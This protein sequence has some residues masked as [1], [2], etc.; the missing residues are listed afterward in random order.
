MRDKRAEAIE[1]VRR[2]REAGFQAY[3]AGGCVR[4][5]LLGRTPKDYDIATDA[6]ASQ[7]QRIFPRTVPVG[8][9]FGVV[10]VLSGGHSF[11]VTTFRSDGAYLDARH[12]SEVRF[13]TAEEDAARRDFTINGMFY[14]PLSAQVLD[15][16][17]GREDLERGI[18]R[19]VGEAPKRIAED[20]LR[21]LRAVRLAARL[22]FRIE[23]K[24]RAAIVAA[25]TS[26]TEMAWERIGE[27]VVL[28][29]REGAARRGIELMA[30]CGLLEPVLPEVSGLRGIPQPPAHHPEGDVFEHTLRALGHLEEGVSETLGLG[31]LLHDI[32]KPS[33]LRS[34]ARNGEVTITF[35]GHAE[36][37]AKMAEEVCQR[38]KRSREVRSRVAYLVGQHSRILHAERMRPAKLKRM[39]REEGFAELLELARVDALAA[40]GDLTHYEFCRAR[41]AEL[42]PEQ[43]HPPRLLTGHDLIE[44]GYRPGPLFGSILEKLE[45]A[46]LEGRLRTK[47]EAVEWVLATFGRPQP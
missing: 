10:L 22:G 6:L 33:A 8:V 39:L 25:C 18:V 9:Q 3:F 47:A 40:R 32:G 46:Q 31:V 20:R 34:L 4:D 43:M 28:I 15:F 7:V 45:D 38:L 27:E 14:D 16:V 17:G 11:E 19:A 13:G 23:E 21:M 30:E 42:G 36:I 5:E 44:L 41:L 35:H 1:I 37:G 12:P 29:L 2:L 24:T 26:I